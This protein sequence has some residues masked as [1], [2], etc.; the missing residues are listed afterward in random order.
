M[1]LMR[2]YLVV[3]VMLILPWPLLSSERAQFWNMGFSNNSKYFSFSQ[4]WVNPKNSKAATELYVVD[5]GRNSFVNGGRDSYQSPTPL[6]PGNNGRNAAL[7]L[8]RKRIALLEQYNINN[9]AQGRLIYLLVSDHES[10]N[11]VSFRDFSTGN[12]YTVTINQRNNPNGAAFSIE[13]VVKYRDGA[14]RRLNIGLPNLYRKNIYDYRLEQVIVAPN[15]RS[16]VFVIEQELDF[17]GS[18]RTRYM[19][20]TAVLDR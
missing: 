16:L 11:N 17:Q 3:V 5:T 10:S 6:S 20:E 7:H 9:V 12:H 2:Y 13:A 1:K 4:F 18:N 8:F 19:V 15:E 14:E